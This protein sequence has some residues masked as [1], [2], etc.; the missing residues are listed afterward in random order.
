MPT[1]VFRGAC[2]VLQLRGTYRP[3]K[4]GRASRGLPHAGLF[5]FQFDA[6]LF[7]MPPRALLVLLLAVAVLLVSVLFAGMPTGTLLF[8]VALL[9]WAQ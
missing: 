1:S 8:L 3:E 9:R 6:P 4:P 5:D 2:G 7:L